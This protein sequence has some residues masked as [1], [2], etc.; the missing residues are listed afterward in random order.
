MKY[1]VLY[2]FMHAGKI[3]KKDEILE[4]EDGTD[5]NYI[6]RLLVINAISEVKDEVE[7]NKKTTPKKTTKKSDDE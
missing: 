1:K 2:S 4:L 3:V 6:K 7:D 5:K